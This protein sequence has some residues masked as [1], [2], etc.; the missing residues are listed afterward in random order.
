MRHTHTHTHRHT[1]RHRHH[2]ARTRTGTGTTAHPA[3][4]L[5]SA[6]RTTP[7]TPPPHAPQL[8]TL[9]T[10]AELSDTVPKKQTDVVTLRLAEGKAVLLGGLAQLHMREGLPFSFTF[11][12]ANA[13]PIHPTTSEK[14]AATLAKHVG[15]LLA[16]PASAERLAELGTFVEQTFTVRGRGWDE[17][18]TDIVLPGLGWIS[19]V[20]SGECTISVAVPQGVVVSSR[21]PMLSGAEHYRTTG[22]KF[23]GTRLT[24]KRGGTKRKR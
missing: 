11:Y 15:G 20:G 7:R 1:L 6:H 19:V 10:T 24:T 21:E 17:V 14:A 18:A 8:T 12:I 3:T 2:S 13:V 22:V 23:T 5:T 16:P 9:L 4:P